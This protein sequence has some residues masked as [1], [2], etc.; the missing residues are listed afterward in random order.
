M[1]WSADNISRV[2]GIPWLQPWGAVNATL[3]GR[4][5]IQV[6]LSIIQTPLLLS[7]IL[8]QSFIF[9]RDV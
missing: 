4:A 6:G 2:I 5:D 9:C 1:D 7:F 8:A 3:I